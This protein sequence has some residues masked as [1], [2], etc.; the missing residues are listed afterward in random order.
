MIYLKSTLAGIGGS[1]LAI[2]LLVVA[3]IIL[4]V[5]KASTGMGM[6]GISIFLPLGMMLLGFAAGFSL[7]FIKLNRRSTSIN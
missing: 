4:N 6:I 2:V 7:M 5:T 3:I 1:I